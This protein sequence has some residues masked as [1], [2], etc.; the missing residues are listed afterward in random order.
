MNLIRWS[1]KL[2]SYNC[3]YLIRWVLD[4]YFFSIRLH[5]WLSSDDQRYYHD[6]PWWYITLIIKGSYTDKS[7]DEDKVMSYGS[8]GFRRATHKHTV[9]VPKGGCWSLLICGR[10]KREW[11]FWV[12]GRF[13][14]RNKYFYNYGNHQCD[15]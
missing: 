8:I 3:T 15:N 7:P 11:G 10:D 5:H 13:M 6:H 14:K 1:E 4:L 12:N 9:E 2:G